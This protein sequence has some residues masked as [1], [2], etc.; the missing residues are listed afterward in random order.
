MAGPQ[1]PEI[2]DTILAAID[3]RL[4]NVMTCMPGKIVTYNSL[5]QTV[6]VQPMVQAVTEQPNGEMVAERQPVIPGCPVFAP[7]GGRFRILAPIKAG[8][9]CIILFTHCAI[10]TFIATG[11]ESVQDDNGRHKIGNAFALIGI[12][13]FSTPFTQI[14][15]NT[16]SIGLDNGPTIEIGQNSIVAG[17]SGA[18]PTF[19]ATA[20]ANAFTTLIG[21]IASAVGGLPG[22][23]PAKTAITTA[24]DTFNTTFGLQTTVFKAT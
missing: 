10:D 19:K 11:R 13:P 22:G 3:A 12:N 17:G 1:T 20:Y 7:S 4:E 5:T 21:A 14:P 15:T 18:Q 2:A 9:F 6:D 8:D 23:T 16:L 24:L